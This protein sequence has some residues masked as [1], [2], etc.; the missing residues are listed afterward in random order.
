MSTHRR[1]RIQETLRQRIM[2][3]VATGALAPGD[4]LPSTRELGL[5]FGADPR[6]AG[7]AY[8]ALALEGLVEVRDRSG[9]YVSPTFPSAERPAAVQR[10]LIVD[11]LT[12][13]IVRGVPAPALCD[14]VR[15]AIAS[16]RLE[17]AVVAATIDQTVGMVR[18][19]SRD[20]GLRAIGL[21][22][23]D[24][25]GEDILPRLI[26]RAQLLITTKA[27]A[28]RMAAMAKRLGKP[29][30]VVGVRDDLVETHWEPLL[31]AK[32]YVV[33]A[34]HRFQRIARSYLGD[35][36]GAGNVRYLV[37]GRDD[38]S[39]VPPTAPTYVTEAARQRLG[40]LRIPGELI[41]PAR[42]FAN[43]CVREIVS[44]MVALNLGTDS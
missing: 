12:E 10:S 28:R 4:R 30:I 38:L 24:L 25:G 31:A 34:D 21:L 3:A 13:G 42:L 20:Y 36:P 15:V 14:L 5:E 9:I 37:A 18:E 8:R 19:L 2:R 11:M 22:G 41:P 39:I 16:R 17:V 44:A 26:R 33:V 6:V 27:H 35:R 40:K 43:D 32:V 7:A 29:L 23:S 1:D